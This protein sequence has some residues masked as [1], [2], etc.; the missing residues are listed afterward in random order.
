MELDCHL[1]QSSTKWRV[2]VVDF[3]SN[4]L[5]KIANNILQWV[6]LCQLIDEGEPAG[7]IALGAAT[8]TRAGE[9]TRGGGLKYSSDN[10]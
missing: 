2:L 7:S 1:H 3:L 6:I 4:R 8:A 5:R 10:G 9:T